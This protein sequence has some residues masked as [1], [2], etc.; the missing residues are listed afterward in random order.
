MKNALSFLLISCLSCLVSYG[1]KKDVFT[2]TGK[3]IL[4]SGVDRDVIISAFGK[5]NRDLIF[6]KYL[7]SN[8][9]F[10]I[11]F[12]FN[13]EY[14]VE[15]SSEN[16]YSKSINVDT[17][18]DDVILKHSED[19]PPFPM[20]VSLFQKVNGV[21]DGFTNKPVGRVFFDEYI[22]GFIA[23]VYTRDFDIKNFINSEKYK[24]ER[25]SVNNLKK[26]GSSSLSEESY[27]VLEIKSLWMERKEEMSYRDYVLMGDSLYRKKM[28]NLARFFYVHAVRRTS[29]DEY[30]N[31]QI[32]RCQDKMEKQMRNIKKQ[33]LLALKKIGDSLYE[34]KNYCKA[35]FI[36]QKA[37]LKAPLDKS[38]DERILN[39][40][41]MI[42][43]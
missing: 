7:K 39:C 24:I 14:Q 42:S 1:Q 21:S 16:F 38:L 36:Y 33:E 26:N 19:I 41:K 25:K 17:H 23:D 40:N 32:L 28:Y 30:C 31:R 37:Q 35:R 8:E 15:F 20:V 5:G 3:V 6:K 12:E 43:P 22:S 27:D 11:K 18:I 34:C 2:V 9:P 10:A 4:E 13:K 29:D